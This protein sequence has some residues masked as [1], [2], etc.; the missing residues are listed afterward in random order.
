MHELVT[1]NISNLN[2]KSCVFKI[3]IIIRQ[4]KKSHNY[5]VIRRFIVYNPKIAFLL[6]KKRIILQK[7][8]FSKIYK[9][10]KLYS[11]IK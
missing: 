11:I 5:L 7:I 6:I 8:K 3:T 9:D 1:N 2:N 10:K 4:K